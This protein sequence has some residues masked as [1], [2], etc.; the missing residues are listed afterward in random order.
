MGHA[1]VRTTELL[2]PPNRRT[3]HSP[4]NVALR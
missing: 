1:T 4:H 2:L 3:R